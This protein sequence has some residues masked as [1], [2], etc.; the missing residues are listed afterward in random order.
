[1]TLTKCDMCKEIIKK[2]QREFSLSL[3]GGH[4]VGRAKSF[5]ARSELDLNLIR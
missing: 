4:P 1:M 3:I 2:D 5:G